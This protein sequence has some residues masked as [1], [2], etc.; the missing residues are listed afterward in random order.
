MPPIDRSPTNPSEAVHPPEGEEGFSFS[1]PEQGW[2]LDPPDAEGVRRGRV[3]TGQLRVWL[4]PKETVRATCERE[5]GGGI[6]HPGL[7]L[8]LDENTS[9]VY[10]GEAQDLKGRLL[11]HL[12]RAPREQGDF[13]TV[14]ILNDGRN[15]V[16]SHFSDHTLRLALEKEAVKLLTERSRRLQVSNTARN[17]PNL[18]L[19]QKPVFNLIADELGAVLFNLSLL[20]SQPPPV[21]EEREVPPRLAASRFP[22][23]SIQVQSAFEGKIGEAPVFIRHST[24]KPRRRDGKYQVTIPLGEPFG[25]ELKQGNGFL[26]VNKGPCYLIPNARLKEWLEPKL[27]LQKVDV[28]FDIPTDRVICAGLNPLP[29]RDFKGVE[30]TSS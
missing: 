8:L 23:Y 25:L 22:R 19:Q 5:L 9:K 17:P 27:T 2:D 6:H 12:Q 10:V 29:V 30:E 21:Q 14:V 18:S 28:F 20:D 4:L 7:Y 24:F 13:T 26:L 1:I 16:H 15:Y 3:K 11:E